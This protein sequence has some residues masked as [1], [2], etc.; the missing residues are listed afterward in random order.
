MK[1]KTSLFA[2]TITYL[3]MLIVQIAALPASVLSLALLGLTAL[4]GWLHIHYA[5]KRNAKID[6]ASVNRPF[7][8]I[9]W[10]LDG[11]GFELP[12][13][14][15]GFYIACS[16]KNVT[17]T[18]AYVQY[19]LSQAGNAA[20]IRSNMPVLEFRFRYGGANWFE[21]QEQYIERIV[22]NF[23]LAVKNWHDKLEANKTAY[24][25]AFFADNQNGSAPE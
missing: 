21:T 22:R 6:W 11:K 8:V 16:S 1:K 3:L 13:R 10:G 5:G 24:V 23:D 12:E 2:L 20:F 17:D 25:K 19:S 14:H 9:D 15:R 7:A 4:V 18:L